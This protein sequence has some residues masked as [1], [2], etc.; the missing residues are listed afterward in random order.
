MPKIANTNNNYWEITTRL[1]A[2]TR[3]FIKHYLKTA[4]SV[5]QDFKNKLLKTARSKEDG[6]SCTVRK[7]K[8][9]TL[10][11]TGGDKFSKLA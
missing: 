1:G 9:F 5:F 6:R 2:S 3:F 10:Y 7:F 11:E 8:I 4:N